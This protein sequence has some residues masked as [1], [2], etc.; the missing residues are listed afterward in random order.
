MAGRRLN[1]NGNRHSKTER[2]KTPH[3]QGAGLTASVHI[4]RQQKRIDALPHG[5]RLMRTRVCPQH[6]P[7]VDLAA[8]VSAAPLG[9]RC[10]AIARGYRLRHPYV[11]VIGNGATDV[12]FREQEAV[13]ILCCGHHCN[14][15]LSRSWVSRWSPSSSVCPVPDATVPVLNRWLLTRVQVVKRDKLRPAPLAM[16][17]VK[18][19]LD[20]VFDDPQWVVFLVQQVAAHLISDGWCDIRHMVCLE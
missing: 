9:V 4:T 2:E 12:V 17:I 13:K 8:S 15:Q 5:F 20:V 14:R 10:P 18:I 7:L 11:I 6:L 16:R 19:L 3:Q 1:G